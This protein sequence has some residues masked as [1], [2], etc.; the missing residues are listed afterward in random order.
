[1]PV[2]AQGLTI[3]ALKANRTAQTLR[4]IAAD[5][6]AAGLRT[7]RKAAW[8]HQYVAAVLRNDVRSNDVAF[9]RLAPSYDSVDLPHGRRL[10][11][12]SRHGVALGFPAQRPGG[13]AEAVANAKSRP[14]R[15]SVIDRVS[16]RAS[17]GMHS[18]AFDSR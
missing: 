17:S 1:M 6:N 12:E 3:H 7:R 14:L 15:D 13:R 5:P 16:M 11:P 18:I 10:A 8:R 9:G 4:Q 2:A